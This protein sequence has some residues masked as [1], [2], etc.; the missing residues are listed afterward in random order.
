MNFYEW[1]AIWNMTIKIL[2]KCFFYSLDQV[3]LLL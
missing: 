3:Q 2:I 1:N